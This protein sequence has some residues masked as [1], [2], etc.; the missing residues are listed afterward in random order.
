MDWSLIIFIVVI[1]W[2]GFRGYRN[3]M[4]KSVSRILSLIAGYACAILLTGT[5]SQVVASQLGLHGIIGLMLSSII[6]FIGASTLVSLIFWTVSRLVFE[7]GEPST[8]STIGGAVVGSLVG[9]LFG[10]MIVWGLSFARDMNLSGAG[11][12][13]TPQESGGIEALANRVAGSAVG[14]ALTMGPAGPE[15]A[16]FSSALLESPGEI[17]QHGQRLM[18]GPE[19]KALVQNPANQQVLSRGDLVA[20]QSLPEF[21]ALAQNPDMRAI[22]AA[23]GLDEEASRNGRSVDAELAQQ[24]VNLW[25]RTQL[26]KNNPRVQEIV[27]NPGFQRKLQSGD[28]MELLN[29]AELLEL[30]KIIFSEQAK[31]DVA[32]E[33]PAGTAGSGETADTRPAVGTSSAAG[34][35]TTKNR[36]KT[37]YRRE[38]E[39][40][41]IFFSD[42]KPPED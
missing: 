2:F 26:I 7:D 19:L 18:E 3:G 31:P 5:F 17:V 16:R 30:S 10:I 1:L 27:N 20:V 32:A 4:L 12:A 39:N 28:P 11:P 13:A 6:L 33:P 21:Q 25:G 24:M 37:L 36:P 41:R 23:A 34:A 14:A 42:E 9:V 38:D 29:S 40:G 22:A 35:V 15:V 8:A